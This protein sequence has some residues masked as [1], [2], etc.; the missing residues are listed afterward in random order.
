MKRFY[1]LIAILCTFITANAQFG[2]GS[3]IVGRISGTLVDSL[4]KKPMDYASVGLYRSGGKSPITGVITD[5]KGNFKL[6]NV[7][8]G[9]YKLSIT[10]IGYPAK[11]I[12]PII[13]TDAKPDK[14]LGVIPVS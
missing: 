11:V 4:T 12:D 2:G 9:S 7:K 5:E 3:T 1:I 6:D 8:P 14:N 13:T 10:F